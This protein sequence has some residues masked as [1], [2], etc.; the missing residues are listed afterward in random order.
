MRV[1]E[2]NYTRRRIGEIPDQPITDPYV[3]SKILAPY[4]VG[5]ESEIL[6]ILALNTKN[7]IIGTQKLYVGNVAGSS[8]RVGEVFR[9]A[10]RE[11]AAAIFIAHNHP[12][13]ELTPSGDDLTITDEISKAGRLL[14]IT[15]LD[16]LIMSDDGRFYSIRQTRGFA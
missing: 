2:Y 10:V 3:A 1:Y 4:F 11:N 7:R 15:L 16:H 5:A 8:V 13:G 9:F 6:V 12:S 14:D